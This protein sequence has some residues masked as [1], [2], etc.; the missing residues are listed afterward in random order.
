[1]VLCAHLKGVIGVILEGI[2]SSKVC[3]ECLCMYVLFYVC[4]GIGFVD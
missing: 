2:H 3:V 1:M 4:V